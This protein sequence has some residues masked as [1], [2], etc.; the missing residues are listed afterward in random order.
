MLAEL[1]M[2]IHD[3]HSQKQTKKRLKRVFQVRTDAEKAAA[4]LAA[5]PVGTSPVS[6]TLSQSPTTLPQQPVSADMITDSD[7]SE[8]LLEGQ[9]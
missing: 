1:K 3:E 9:Q 8:G 4:A 7:S 6:S 2:H 5:P